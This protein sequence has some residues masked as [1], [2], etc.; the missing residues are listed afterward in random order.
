MFRN[1]AKRQIINDNRNLLT[2][3]L[4]YIA[5]TSVNVVKQIKKNE[6]IFVNFKVAFSERSNPLRVESKLARSREPN[7]RN[8]IITYFYLIYLLYWTP[9]FGHALAYAYRRVG[10]RANDGATIVRTFAFRT[11]RD[12]PRAISTTR[13]V[14][15]RSLQ[16]GCERVFDLA[17]PPAPISGS[18]D[19]VNGYRIKNS[20]KQNSCFS[21]RK[22]NRQPECRPRV[23]YLC[24]ADPV[25]L[26]LLVKSNR[27]ILYSRSLVNMLKSNCFFRY[28]NET[29]MRLLYYLSD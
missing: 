12:T 23:K 21:R 9:R 8:I 18:A 16:V 13:R 2:V 19:V 7:Y 20:R 4:K 29:V 25:G 11:S 26:V 27:V 5:S 17:S 22:H 1:K 28:S 14:R 24:C 6:L 10:F 3:S 15:L